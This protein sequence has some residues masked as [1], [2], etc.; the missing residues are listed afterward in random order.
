MPPPGAGEAAIEALAALHALPMHEGL[1]WGA[2]PAD[3]IPE[4]ELPLHRLGFAA[5]ERETGARPLA[6]APGR[7]LE[8]PFGFAHGDATAAHILLAKGAARS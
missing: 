3:L 1:N 8:T 5:D 6:A 2:D 4:G 7:R